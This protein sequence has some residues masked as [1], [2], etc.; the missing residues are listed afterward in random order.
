MFSWLKRV[1]GVVELEKQVND[2]KIRMDRLDSATPEVEKGSALEITPAQKEILDVLKGNRMA[3]ETIAEKLNKSR[4]WVSS[5][6]NDLERDGRVKETG[7]EG[8][9]VFYEVV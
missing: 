1:L 9:T 3:T 5:L 2:L 4:S 6:I 8:K 7:K